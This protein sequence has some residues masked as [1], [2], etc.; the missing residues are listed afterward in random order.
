MQTF[1][2]YRTF[3]KTAACLDMP[4]L[5]KQRSETIQILQ[6][7]R[8]ERPIVGN[9][10]AYEMW[11]GYEEALVY[12]GLIITHEWRIVRG[13]KDDTWGQFAEYARDYNMLRSLTDVAEQKPTPI[14]YP[15]WMGE[16]WVLRSHR[17]RLIE[18]MAHHY[19]EQFGATPVNMPYLWPK[20]DKEHRHGYRLFLA[21]ADIDRVKNGERKL[22][23]VL[24][25]NTET[26]EVVVTQ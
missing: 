18:K 23:R 17:S 9:V 2:T 25:L 20:W 21:R 22:P 16:D 7:L 14:V 6:A 3:A 24:E 11:R 15:P 1:I 26:G 13:F 10:H 19:G 12:Y 4:R 5:G 8:G